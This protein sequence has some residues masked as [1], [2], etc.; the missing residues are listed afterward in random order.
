VPNTGAPALVPSL[1]TKLTALE[2]AVTTAGGTFEINPTEMGGQTLVF[3]Q[4]LFSIRQEYIT[5]DALPLVGSVVIA[6]RPQLTAPPGFPCQTLID[7]VNLEIIVHTMFPFTPDNA[8][9]AHDP[10]P[11]NPTAATHRT[12][13]AFDMRINGLSSA[14]IDALATGVGLV[15]PNPVTEPDHFE[16]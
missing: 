11:A 3:Q 2:A 8:P 14:T 6:G 1:A 5:L 13:N 10:V 4:H 16:Q 12:G 7:E 9:W 15:R